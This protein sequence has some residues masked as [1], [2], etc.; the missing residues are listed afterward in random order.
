MTLHQATAEHILQDHW[1][2]YS[3]WPNALEI[4]N[5]MKLGNTQNIVN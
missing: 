4:R 5:K 1:N 2:I 3:N